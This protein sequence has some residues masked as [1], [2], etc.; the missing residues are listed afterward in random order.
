[1]K[2]TYYLTALSIAILAL[3]GTNIALAETAT[4]TFGNNNR[5]E[6]TREKLNEQKT[7]FE[8]RK[9]RI[10]STT[11]KI[12]DRIENRIENR[13]NKIA[14]GTA[15]MEDR[16]EKRASSTE[17]RRIRLEE[18]FKTGIANQI[19]KVNDRL[20]DAIERLKRTDDRLVAHIVKLKARNVD[21]SKADLLLVD[22]QAKLV[23]ATEKVN[24]LKTSLESILTTNISTT[25]KNTIKAK[26]AEANT[27]VKA[28]HEAY[29]KVVESLKPG[30]N[31]TATST[32]TT[33]TP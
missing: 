4:S 21:T 24:T 8:E 29:V 13:E 33:T 26:T 20:G 12:E 1:M 9:I 22:A 32:A 10:A 18:K 31:T 17:A 16:Q 3:V 2:K 30:I 6:Q 14:S 27:Y 11:A 5:W 7:K 23:I 19:S 28:A 15:R 25:T